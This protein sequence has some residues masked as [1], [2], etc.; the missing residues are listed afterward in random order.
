M[1][2]TTAICQY[3]ICQ[4]PFKTTLYRI[5]VGKGKYCSK[6]CQYA[7]HITPQTF[8]ERFWNN[9]QKCTHEESCPYCC[10]E[11]AGYK[12]KH[13]YGY[14]GIRERGTLTH[15]LVWEIWHTTPLMPNHDAA[16]YCHNPSCCNP[17]HIHQATR[18]ENIL[19]S[20]RDNR[21]QKGEKNPQCKLQES[22]IFDI[23][24]MFHQ[25]MKQK[26]ISKKYPTQK[27]AI[28]QILHRETWKHVSIPNYLIASA[29]AK[30]Y[31]HRSS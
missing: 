4:K 19:D 10:W 5:S 27:N 30:F 12:N 6:A 1:P 21:T 23:F 17:N 9:I 29:Q 3:S 22:D 20:V 24:L 7:S 26:E 28:K 8:I 13:G 15:R 16:H 11:W 14:C 2:N 18:Q 25:G 31:R